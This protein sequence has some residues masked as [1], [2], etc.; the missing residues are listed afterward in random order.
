[1]HTALNRIQLSSGRFSTV[2]LVVSL[3]IAVMSVLQLYA[4]NSFALTS[5]I[6][7]LKP[8]VSVR[9]SRRYGAIGGK[10]KDNYVVG[11]DLDADFTPLFNWNTKQVFVYVTAEYEGSRSDVNNRV[12]LWDKIITSKKDAV[13]DLQ[14]VRG[15]YSV[16]DVGP[17]L[18]NKNATLR[19]EW[20]LQPHVGFLMT[21]TS[22]HG[23]ARSQDTLTFP[24]A[25]AKK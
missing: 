6:E 1:M 14:N 2:V 11:F 20:N 13:L 25:K 22:S 17:T 21:G 19:V 9:H 24:A 4:Q 8:Q 5:R 3:V 7:N 23:S 12:T 16:Y 15:K 10:A 18:A